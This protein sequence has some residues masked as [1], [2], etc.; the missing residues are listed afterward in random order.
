MGQAFIG[1][2]LCCF[3]LCMAGVQAYF[4]NWFYN[5]L[6][7]FV[8]FRKA[9][10]TMISGAWPVLN[11]PNSTRVSLGQGICNLGRAWVGNVLVSFGSG[12][13][14]Q[15]ASR[16]RFSWANIEPDLHPL[17]NNNLVWLWNLT[18]VPGNGPSQEVDFQTIFPLK[19]SKSYFMISA[20][21]PFQFSS[22]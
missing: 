16:V 3:S 9:D 7:K 1:L 20:F 19:A 12:L 11:Q 10:E 22:L 15:H 4:L 13:G 5:F 2:D 8:L 6:L 17:Y 21:H 18:V 14:F